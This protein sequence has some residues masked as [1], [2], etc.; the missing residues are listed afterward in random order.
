MNNA[1][2]KNMLM[3]EV[4]DSFFDNSIDINERK[5]FFIWANEDWHNNPAFGNDVSLI[6]KNN[7]SEENLI[8]NINNLMKYLTWLRNAC[9]KVKTYFMCSKK[10]DNNNDVAF[11]PFKVKFF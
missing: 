4:I 7:Y 3:K 2:N 8:K 10:R 1:T 11:K 5:I 9:N 6:I